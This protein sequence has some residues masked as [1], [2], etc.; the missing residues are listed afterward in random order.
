[1]Q[2][3]SRVVYARGRGRGRD[4]GQGSS[5]L[6]GGYRVS[7]LQEKRVMGT[8]SGEVAQQREYLIPLNRTLK[9]D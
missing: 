9:N 3:D 6:M 7:D 4:K 5:C 1:M 8:D 2:T